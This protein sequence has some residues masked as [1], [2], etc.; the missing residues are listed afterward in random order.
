M[1]SWRGSLWRVTELEG[2][3]DLVT[4]SALGPHL[5]LTASRDTTVKVWSLTGDLVHS[6]RGHTGPVTGVRL[7]SREDNVRLAA[8]LGLSEETKETPAG[9]AVSASQD[10]CLKVWNLESGQCVR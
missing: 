4:D 6:L 2:H 10:C 3:E 8:A 7:L 5:A 1:S 9:L